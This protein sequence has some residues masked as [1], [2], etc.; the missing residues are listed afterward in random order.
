V[1]VHLKGDRHFVEW[2]LPVYR[3]LIVI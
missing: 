3:T 1:L 2:L